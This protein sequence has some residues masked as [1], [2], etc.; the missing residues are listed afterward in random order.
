M[1]LQALKKSKTQ[2][3][4]NK[5]T[6]YHKVNRSSGG[7]TNSRKFFLTIIK[8]INVTVVSKVSVIPFLPKFHRRSVNYVGVSKTFFNCENIAFKYLH[9]FFLLHIK[10]K[11][12][13]KKI[14]SMFKLWGQ[15]NNTLQVTVL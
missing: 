15:F 11:W 7:I 9:I 1:L 3:K 5:L 2:I 12:P 10:Y 6:R 8:G 14:L 13:Q 4:N